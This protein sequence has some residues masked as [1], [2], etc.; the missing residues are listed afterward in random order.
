MAVSRFAFSTLLKKINPSSEAV[1]VA[2][3]LPGEVREWLQEHEFETAPP[4]SRLIGSYGRKTATL[5]I[6]DVD[7]LVFLPVEALDRSPES[8]LRE[9]KGVLHDY[10]GV[11]VE[12]SPQRRSIRLDFHAHD[13]SMDLVAAVAE[14]GIDEPLLIPDRHQK[15][16]IV[17]DPLGYGRT[18]SAANSDHGLKLIPLIKLMKGWRSEKMVV[19][20]PKSY[21]LEV[22]VFHAVDSGAVALKGQAT[23]E[24]VVDLFEH[25]A[26]KYERLMDQGHGVPRVTDP[27][28]GVVIS[29][30]CERSH[31]ETFM[32]R[33]GDA[34]AAGRAALN[35]DTDEAAA[36][37][38][39]KIFG[40]LWPSA[41]EVKAEARAAALD[42]T[43][44]AAFV[45]PTG[46]VS[47]VAAAGA[48]LTRPT[49]FHGESR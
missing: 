30:M 14:D 19:R 9:L 3:T 42:A 16:W 27:Q 15:K 21:L 44:G 35:A 39:R 29:N 45:S 18:L 47:R 23:A 6:K 1:E 46:G 31:F 4:H 13:L 43:P 17:S 10:P 48:H 11:G 34:A 26:A 7:T 20:R 25:I 37:H 32:R 36:V 8:V 22:M 40:S 24:N 28:T 5:G 41:E 12:A 38:W 49:I 2:K 33:V